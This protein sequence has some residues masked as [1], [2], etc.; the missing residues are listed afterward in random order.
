MEITGLPPGRVLLKGDRG[1]DVAI[2]QQRL[3]E[4]GFLI[5]SADGYFGPATFNAVV[6]LQKA[7]QLYPDGAIGRQVYELLEIKVDKEQGKVA[8]FIADGWLLTNSI[9][10]KRLA[11]PVLLQPPII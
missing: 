10:T 9:K 5:G 2:V 4:K 1:Y 3:I 6:R 7:Y 11:L 8:H